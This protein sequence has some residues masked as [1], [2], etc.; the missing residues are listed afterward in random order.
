MDL[1]INGTLHRVDVEPD[2]PLL[3]VVR[4]CLGL[5]GTKFGCGVGACGACTVHLGGV[6]VRSCVLPVA[7]VVGQEVTTIEGLEHE[8]QA[9]WVKHQVPQCG[10]CQSGQLMAASALLRVNPRPTDE[11]IDRSMT[12]LCRC[13]TYDRIRQGI[14]AAAAELSRRSEEKSGEPSIDSGESSSPPTEP[15]SEEGR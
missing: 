5:T 6:A 1:K 9:A 4:D 11:D 8:V 14:H 15:S 2:T 3:W 7:A 12:N 10:Y 13:A